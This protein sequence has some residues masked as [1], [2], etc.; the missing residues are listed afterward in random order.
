[1]PIPRKPSPVFA[2]DPRSMGVDPEACRRGL[3]SRSR[4][5]DDPVSKES[6]FLLGLL[7]DEGLCTF[8]DPEVL[9]PLVDDLPGR[10]RP[11]AAPSP[12]RPAGR[13]L[14]LSPR[15][16]HPVVAADGRRRC[17]FVDLRP[18]ADVGERFWEHT[19]RTDWH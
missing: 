14:S 5:Y 2:E 18:G 12:R 13:F 3:R 15:S 17:P 16:A 7:R 6:L 10:L 9:F 1:M 4:A 8:E 19:F 11:R